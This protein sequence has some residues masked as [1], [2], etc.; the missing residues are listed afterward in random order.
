MLLINVNTNKIFNSSIIGFLKRNKKKDKK[1]KN[2]ENNDG[3]ES[4]Q[5]ENMGSDGEDQRKSG[6]PTPEVDDEGYSKPTSSIKGTS[7]AATDPWADFNNQSKYDSS[8]DDSDN[9]DD[10]TKKIKVV[11]KSVQNG[12][13]P[14]SASV[15]EL[16][17]AIGGLE[18]APIPPVSL[19]SQK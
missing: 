19:I 9:D 14:I 7:A 1:N 4:S 18:I 12:N 5:K 16:R 17:S 15:D 13:P 6:T 2:K 8:S 10:A 3:N 11:I